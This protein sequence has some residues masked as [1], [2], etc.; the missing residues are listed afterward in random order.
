MVLLDEPAA[1]VNPAFLEAL[2]GWIGQLQAAGRTFVIVEHNIPWVFG[3]A[4][5]VVVLDRG[6]RIAEGPPE[7]IKQD[8]RVLE[9]YLGEVADVA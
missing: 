7:A 8:D 4:D 5:R 3:L 9:A 6:T 1:G 2:Q